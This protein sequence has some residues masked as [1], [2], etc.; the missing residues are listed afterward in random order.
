MHN[1]IQLDQ[2]LHACCLQD[3]VSLQS[4]HYH[5]Q[6]ARKKLVERECLHQPKAGLVVRVSDSTTTPATSP[7]TESSLPTTSTLQ[8]HKKHQ[9]I[10]RRRSPKQVSEARALA[11][12]RQ[13][14]L[15]RPVRLQRL[16][17]M[18]TITASSLH[19][20]QE[21]IWFI[22]DSMATPS[23]QRNFVL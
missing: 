10:K 21:Q 6:M 4:L 13:N 8:L 20:R 11:N 22:R 12:V 5:V 9:T 18:T 7:L 1:E 3:V 14:K 2:A 17:A 23:H 15:L 19:S 16:N